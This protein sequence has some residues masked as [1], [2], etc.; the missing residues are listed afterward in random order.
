MTP[1]KILVVDDEPLIREQLSALFEKYGFACRHAGNAR[2]ARALLQRE[3]FDLATIDVIMPGE[4]GIELTKWIKG[5]NNTPVIML[6]S[7]DDNIDAVVG[8][9]IG[10]DDYIAKPFDPRLLLA[11]VNAVLRRSG[12]NRPADDS[13]P[14]LLVLDSQERCLKSGRNRISLSPREFAFIKLL[15]DAGNGSVSRE[16]LSLQVFD[17]EWN[18]M[19]RAIDNFVARL[20]QKIEDKPGNPKYIVTVRHVGYMIPDGMIQLAP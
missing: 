19:D 12:D 3:T 1:K 14:G 9:E 16:T 15:V 18:P 8:L 13:P 5:T 10:A 6:T 20:R 4:S 2:E 11:R 17:K 7:L